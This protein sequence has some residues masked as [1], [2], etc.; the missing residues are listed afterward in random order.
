[1]TMQKQL[2]VIVAL[3]VAMMD[4]SY[5]SDIS[6]IHNMAKLHHKIINKDQFVDIF[7]PN[8]KYNYIN[9]K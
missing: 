1:M 6:D 9:S 2:T 5:S 4:D 3:H 8:G 7:N